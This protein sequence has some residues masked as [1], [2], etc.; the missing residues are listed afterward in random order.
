M[1][2]ISKL[3]N[4]LI[5]ATD[6]MKDVESVALNLLVRVGSRYESLEN[7]GMSHFLEH[8]AF[9]GTAKR[10]A[11]QIA[12]AFDNIG[13]DFNA[14]TSREYTVYTSKTLKNHVHIAVDIISDIIQN[15]IFDPQEIDR[16]L[17][18]ILQE[19][20][21]SNDTPDDIIFDYFQ[22]KSFDAQAIGRSILGREEIISTFNQDHFK[23]YISKYYRAP[24]M[25]LTLAGNIDHEEI[26]GLVEQYFNKLSSDI[27][28]DASN[29]YYTGGN[30][31]TQKDLEQIQFI[32]GFEGCSYKDDLYIA[33]QLMANILGG[34]M[35]SRLFQEVREKRGL[36][37]SIYSF[38]NCYYDA[39]LFCVYAGTSSENINELYK[40]VLDQLHIA[41]DSIS[42]EEL[43]RAKNQLKSSLLM[44]RDSTS[45]RSADLARNIAIHGRYITT[46][47]LVTKISTIDN[48]QIESL[49][50]KFIS[51]AKPT[52]ALL[53]KTDNFVL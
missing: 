39:G 35:S 48:I 26:T 25:I 1:I 16:E 7:N 23:E 13:G 3:K 9:K 27:S 2:N 47:E 4:G 37:Y 44:G 14:Y 34:G 21:A 8:M 30:I 22:E 10:S 41:S 11:Y 38:N 52:I 28:P 20:A 31:I 6:S 46:E 17:G 53:G 15:S 45:Y 51:C 50:K 36:A 18:V 49:L 29:C 33:S 32:L 40:V 5:V 12:E 43:E 24:N 42:E 19:I